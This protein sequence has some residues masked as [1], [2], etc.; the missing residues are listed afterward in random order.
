MTAEVETTAPNSQCPRAAALEDLIT[1]AVLRQVP[2]ALGWAVSATNAASGRPDHF[3]WDEPVDVCAPTD[4]GLSCWQ[5]GLPDID[6]DA[7]FQLTN[8]LPARR[9]ARHVVAIVEGFQP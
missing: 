8:T 4:G 6:A 2:G 1:A 9:G 5:V 7:V 3:Y